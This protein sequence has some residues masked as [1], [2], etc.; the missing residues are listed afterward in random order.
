L[1]FKNFQLSKSLLNSFFSSPF[2]KEAID[3]SIR[4]F[5]ELS[6]SYQSIFLN[7]SQESSARKV[8]YALNQFFR[9]YQAVLTNGSFSFP[10]LFQL[11]VEKFFVRYPIVRCTG[12]FYILS[13]MCFFLF[14]NKNI[15]KKFSKSTLNLTAKLAWGALGIGFVLHS[16]LLL[17]KAVAFACPPL[18]TLFDCTLF[19]TWLSIVVG[20]L[21]FAVFKTTIPMIGLLILTEGFFLFLSGL[22]VQDLLSIKPHFNLSFS[23]ILVALGYGILF[24]GGM[25]S[26]FVLAKVL[27][28]KKEASPCL[29]TP[30]ITLSLYLG[31]LFLVIGLLLE[32]LLIKSPHTDFWD[33]KE[34]WIA[35]SICFYLALIHLTHYK[36]VDS[37]LVAMGSCLGIILLSF[38][39]CGVSFFGEGSW[40]FSEKEHI[41]GVFYLIYIVFEFLF[42]SAVLIRRRSEYAV[43]LK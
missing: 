15:G 31:N 1:Q 23:S 18:T 29:F 35:V 41:K 12:I 11:K 30:C 16:G 28:E 27:Q 26:H 14:S 24:L 38:A 42:I 4:S 10:T 37:F 20:F 32:S 6:S 21:F 13:L 17:F 25:L 3:D 33:L 39:S 43:E 9:L 36:W 34:L 7:L 5:E 8:A 40:Q 2:S 19:V 22:H